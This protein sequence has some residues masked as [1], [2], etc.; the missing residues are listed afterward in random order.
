MFIN[1]ILIGVIKRL[2]YVQEKD[3]CVLILV[4]TIFIHKQANVTF[5]FPLL[6]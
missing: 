6:V 2:H 1:L 3:F 5:Y 4:Y